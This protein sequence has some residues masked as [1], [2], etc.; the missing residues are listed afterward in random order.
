M[1]VAGVSSP[2][3]AGLVNRLGLWILAMLLLS[4]AVFKVRVM[5]GLVVHPFVLALIVA[6]G[7]V[8]YASADTFSRRKRGWYSPEWQTWNT[9]LIL[10]GLAVGAAV[11]GLDNPDFVY[12]YYVDQMLAMIQRNWVRPMVGSGVEATVNYRIQRDGRIAEVRIATS[13]GIN[14]FD[15]AALRAVQASTPLPPL[16]RA[17][18]EGSLGV[19][20]IFR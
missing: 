19:N 17:F 7:W 3:H 8:L 12:G 18:R 1:T 20:L 2:A 14:S 13:S 16:P 15:L 6:W 10:L 9:P 11:A 4:P 5:G